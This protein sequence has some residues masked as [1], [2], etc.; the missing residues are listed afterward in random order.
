MTEIA[1][2]KL[3][4]LEVE[5]SSDFGKEVALKE[6]RETPKNVLTGLKRL[7]YLLENETNIPKEM[8]KNNER[9]LMNFLRLCK[10]YPESAKEKIL[11]HLELKKK[12]SNFLKNSEIIDLKDPKGKNSFYVLKQRD[13]LGRRVII[14]KI[15][16]WKTSA[17]DK[18]E[19]FCTFD[20]IINTLRLEPD[21]QINGIVAIMDMKN[22]S[23]SQVL[24]MTPNF[25]KTLTDYL[26]AYLPLRFKAYHIINNPAIVQPFIKL[27][28][29]LLNEKFR[30][31]ILV[32]GKDMKK[33]H[34]HIAVDC[35]PECY[36]GCGKDVEV[37]SSDLFD[38]A[39]VYANDFKTFQE[40]ERID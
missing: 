15:E 4:R 34:R 24:Q 40:C 2:E 1:L 27:A 26:S 39:K 3:F 37:E 31:R 30:Q 14:Q 12:F 18:Y 22:M 6:L 11:C 5:D 21:T 17:V 36:G 29:Q 9:W 20:A 28:T 32:H 33:L 35:L 8:P 13:Q 7:K 38:I 16:H 10:F 23:F 25:A 19:L